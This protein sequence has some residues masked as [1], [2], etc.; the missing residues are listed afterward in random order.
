MPN[1]TKF[2]ERPCDRVQW[3]LNVKH[4]WGCT[5]KMYVIEGQNHSF[6]ISP[7]IPFAVDSMYSRQ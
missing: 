6:T 2:S 5:K 7:Q 4:R 3:K 1:E